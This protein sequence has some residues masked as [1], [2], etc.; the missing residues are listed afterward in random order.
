[1]TPAEQRQGESISQRVEREE[2]DPTAEDSRSDDELIRADDDSVRVID[3]ASI[4]DR[5]LDGELVSEV[6]PAGETGMSAEEAS[7]HITDEPP[8]AVD[9]PDSYVPTHE[10][11]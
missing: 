4:D 2:P 11:S 10:P 3:E 8:G 9:G 5:D 7:V 6:E 1:V